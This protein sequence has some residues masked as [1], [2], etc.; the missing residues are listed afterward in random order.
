MLMSVESYKN[1]LNDGR[2]VYYRGKSVENVA[3]HPA[4]GV[5]VSHA[6][7]RFSTASLHGMPFTSRSASINSGTG[8]SGSLM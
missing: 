5:P 2:V 1:S 4:L 3:A 8:I 6:S 7:G